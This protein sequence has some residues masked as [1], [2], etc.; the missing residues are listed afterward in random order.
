[1]I[2]SIVL[3]HPQ[4]INL[5]RDS[6]FRSKLVEKYR[7]AC[8]TTKPKGAD[9]FESSDFFPTYASWN[10]CL[11]ETSVILTVWE[12]ADQLI[13][14][15]DVAIMHTDIEPHF[16]PTDIWKKI[17]KWIKENNKRSIGLIAPANA[18]GL[19]DDWTIPDD[20]PVTVDQDP[21]MRHQFDNDVHVWDFI[22]DYSLDL[23][24][25]AMDVKPSMIYSHQF[26]CSRL[27]FDHLGNELYKI[28]SRLR[29]GDIGF[30]T[31]H[32]FERLIS[33]ILTKYGGDPILST[34]FW[35]HASSAV[36]GP[37]ELSL[38]GPRPLKYYKVSTRANSKTIDDV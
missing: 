28:A 24:H 7:I 6:V 27:T 38:Y 23:W 1:L 17:S 35:H 37:G 19:W 3:S 29:L 11:F 25:Y 10:S 14:D 33:L 32:M 16:K 18:I 9:L 34:A 5:L 36:A 26:A 2:T 21:F 4:S 12:H 31:P 13:G 8:G 15:N 20:Y 22:K 30:W